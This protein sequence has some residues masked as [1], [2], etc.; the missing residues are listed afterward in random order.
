MEYVLTL[1][2]CSSIANSCLP[3]HTYPNAFPDAYSCM[4]QGYKSSLENFLYVSAIWQD[5]I[6]KKFANEAKISDYELHEIRPIAP[7]KIEPQVL[8]SEIVIPFAERGK[9]SSLV[10]ATRLYKEILSGKEFSIAAKRFSRS[11]SSKNGGEIGLLNENSLPANIK[12]LTKRL[13]PGQI[14]KPT[15]I[16]ESIVILKIN[17]RIIFKKPIEKKFEVMFVQT[18]IPSKNEKNNCGIHSSLIIGPKKLSELN[19][20][21]SII[22]KRAQISKEYI[23]KNNKE[24]RYVTLCKRNLMANKEKLGLIRNYEFNVN[25]DNFAEKLMLELYRNASV[26]LK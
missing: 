23:Y 24:V 20:K 22:L 16:S 3:P 26:E 21:L 6:V 7:T 25:L 10:L 4:V 19:K 17:D 15:R 1:I 11:P 8:L 2:L 13:Q 18:K 5:L 14:S 9:E 12:N